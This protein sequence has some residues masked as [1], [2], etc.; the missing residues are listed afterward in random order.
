MNHLNQDR[1]CFATKKRNHSQTFYKL[2]EDELLKVNGLLKDGEMAVYFYLCV[3]VPFDDSVF[4]LNVDAIAKVL[5]KSTRTIQRALK[6]IIELELIDPILF[7][8]FGKTTNNIESQVKDCL[9]QQLGGLQEVSTP[10]GRIDLLT[11]TEI[12]EVKRVSDW[13]SALGQVLAYSGFYPDYKK[14]IH[15]FGLE[16]DQ[17][18]LST[19]KSTCLP[20]DVE[21]TFEIVEGK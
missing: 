7:P 16:A 20:F 14:R 1:N 19:I 12:I 18:Q 9:Q 3:K 2:T 10:A 4:E 17:Q 5:G 8:G 13:K 11:E 6:R 15:L 21:V